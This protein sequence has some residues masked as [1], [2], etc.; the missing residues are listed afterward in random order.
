MNRNK[1]LFLAQF[2]VLLAIEAVFCFTPLGS[3]PAI[4]P[5][6]ATLMMIPVVI[7]AL[8]LGTFAG[9]LMGF[10]AGLFSFIVW[11]FMPPSPLVA[12]IFTPFVS[13]G[14]FTGNFGSILI[15]FVP[16][17]LAGT[18]TGLVYKSLSKA[19]KNKML[20]RKYSKDIISFSTGA[21]IG[22][23]VNTF[24]V[25][26]GIWLFFG[27]QYASIAEGVM[28]AIIGITILTSGIPEAVVAAVAASGVC[29]P[30]KRIL[31]SRSPQPAAAEISETEI[32]EE[33][34]E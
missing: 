24:G 11:T 7:T 10:F 32:S 25:M 9:T 18:V 16:R 12:F 3:I 27:S 23:L 6:V 19:L 4:G 33:N 31:P 29:V 8:L 15:C 26:G 30:M 34:R 13:V 2:G 21:A 5:I 28:I 20:S 14:E 1:T 17:I 22:S